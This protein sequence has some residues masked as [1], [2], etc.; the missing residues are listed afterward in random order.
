M[1]IKEG[2]TRISITLTDTQLKVLHRIMSVKGYGTYTRAIRLLIDLYILSIDVS[3][4]P[5]K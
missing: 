5:S 1:S 4:T 2:N 3:Q